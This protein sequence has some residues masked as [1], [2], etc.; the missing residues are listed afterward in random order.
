[1]MPVI[2][3]V[4]FSPKKRWH[5]WARKYGHVSIFAFTNETWV[6]LDLSRKNFDMRTFYA[7]DQVNDYLSFMLHYYTVLKFGEA[8]PV[9]NSFF[10]PMTCV[11]FVKHALGIKSRALRPDALYRILIDKYDAEIMNDTQG[12]EG[13][14]GTKTSPDEG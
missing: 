12:A 6:H 10:A 2:W 9:S 5:F 3:H 11:S 4:A 1:M 8:K 14:C 13:N 7:H